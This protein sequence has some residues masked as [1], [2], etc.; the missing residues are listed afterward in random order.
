MNSQETLPID[1]GITEIAVQGFKSLYEES[2]IEI[3]PLTIL[4][5]ANSSG[6]SSI[7][8]PLLLIKQ[9]LEAPF[10]PDGLLLNGP[11][12][13]FTLVRQ[14]LSYKRNFSLESLETD[15]HNFELKIKFNSTEISNLKLKNIEVGS[16]FSQEKTGLSV[17]QTTIVETELQE[18]ISELSYTLETSKEII[19]EQLIK[20]SD[21]FSS[22]RNQHSNL[23]K[24]FKFNI[25]KNRFFL[26]L[27]CDSL[28]KIPAVSDELL[29]IP[30]YD[31]HVKINE[32]THK[33]LDIIHL[34]G[35]RSIPKR[36][37]PSIGINERFLGVFDNYFASIIYHWRIT[38]DS[39]IE[40]LNQYLQDLGLT[41][42][43]TASLPNDVSIELKVSL[44]KKYNDV[45]IN[46][47][48]VGFGVSQVLPVLVALLV[49]KPGQLVYLE[50]PELH[51]HPRAQANL[52]QPLIDAAN[53]GVKV[54]VET[55]S[56]LLLT[57]IKTLVAE[58]AIDPAKL[59]LHW[60]SRGDD[61][62]TKI[63]SKELD[64]VGAYGEFPIDFSDV[65]FE[66]DHRYINAASRQLLAKNKK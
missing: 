29:T 30:L 46:I 47:A 3:R 2:H 22:S 57:R 26:G 15:N 38:Q 11:N 23:I 6:K 4:A 50:Q 48:D 59:I 18:K 60:F 8:Q 41:S 13:K 53:R 43:V 35:L 64:K 56:D 28:I 33:I 51:L 65:F 40:K 49:A 12:V 54:V 14:I 44:S 45:L 21:F 34:P 10:D 27:V 25:T 39:R 42:K 58:E 66:E 55:H 31:N 20:Y 16:L 63:T 5:G 9:T 36:D 62:I 19:I 24:N 32:L 61:G 17:Y 7:M 52:A 37:Y 1:Q